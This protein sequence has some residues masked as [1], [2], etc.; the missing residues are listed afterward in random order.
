MLSESCPEGVRFNFQVQR[1]ILENLERHCLTR[2][3]P[4]LQYQVA[5]VDKRDE[6][7]DIIDILSIL[8]SSQMP[9]WNGCR[10]K[11]PFG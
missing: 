9:S 10:F 7:I 5:G 2:L 11:G 6:R 3:G 4:A 1:G 8:E